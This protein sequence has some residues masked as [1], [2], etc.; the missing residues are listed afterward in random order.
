MSVVA[1]PASVGKTAGRGTKGT[2]ARKNVPAWFEG[3]QMPLQRRVPKLKGFTNPNRVEYA[4]VNV[5]VLA[6]YFTDG[7]VTPEELYAHG[8]AHKGLTGEDPGPW[9]DDHALTVK[10]HAFSATAKAKIE[11]PGGSSRA[12][13]LTRVAK[14]AVLKAFLN[15]FRVPDLRNKIL[16]TLFV[17]AIYRFGA[18]VPVP[19]VDF[20]VINDAVNDQGAGGFLELINMFSGG[21]LGAVRRVLAGHHALHHQL[22]HHAAAHRRHPRLQRWQEQGEVRHQEDQPVRRATSRSCWRC[23]S[24]PGSCSC[25]TPAQQQNIPD[26]FPP[27]PSPAPTCC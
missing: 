10:A 11:A 12:H 1:A 25:S 16:F 17:I 19:V 26:I 22:D 13:R 23:C 7:E 3:G 8:L 21:A 14:P 20:S 4:P 18:H 6:T 27:G 5:E 9:R 24:P 2:G 15:A